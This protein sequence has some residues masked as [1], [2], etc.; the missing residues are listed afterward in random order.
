MCTKLRRQKKENWKHLANIECKNITK[1]CRQA[2]G[3]PIA[4][5][6]E[7]ADGDSKRFWHEIN[8]LL[9]EKSKDNKHVELKDMTTGEYISDIPNYMNA[10]FANIGS[11]LAEKFHTNWTFWGVTKQ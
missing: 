3:N 4:N 6:I 1:L 2:K 8:R 9:P 11:K 7:E 5:K 10:N